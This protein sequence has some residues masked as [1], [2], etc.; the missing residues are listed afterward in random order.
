[1]K[2]AALLLSTLAVLSSATAS[3][4]SVSSSGGK[5]MFNGV[6]DT[7]C[8]YTHTLRD[9]PL[10]HPGAPGASHVHDF[11]GNR[12][13]DSRSTGKRL[14]GAARANPGDASCKDALDRSAY[15]APALYQDGKILLPH[16]V[17]VYYRHH[18]NVPAKPFPTGFGMITR[19]HFWWCG[20]GTTKVRDGTV[21]ACPKGRLFV[22]LQF[23]NCWDGERLFSKNG[24]HVSFGRRLCDAAHPVRLPQL[25]MFLSYRVD[26]KAHSYQLSSGPPRT[27]HADFLNAWEPG[28]LA[29]LVTTCLN[30]G[31]M[32]CER[33]R[34]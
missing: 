26:G 10:M 18:A 17:H 12:T 9:D 16:Q 11:F 21:P 34:R 32:H 23:P 7:R 25:T 6:F 15:W 14:L 13:T 22:I 29:R 3:V 27:G 2:L 33:K 24:S 30:Q 4:G 28:R 1:L 20:P 31:P 19:D 5:P 8:P